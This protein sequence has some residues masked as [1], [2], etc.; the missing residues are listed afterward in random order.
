MPNHTLDDTTAA[1][2]YQWPTCTGCQRPLRENELTRHACRPCQDRATRHLDTIRDLY[3][4]L[5]TAAALTPTARAGR[6]DGPA[7][8][9]IHAPLPLRV[10]VIDLTAP[11]GIGTR[12]QA[13]EDSWR[14]A[15]GRPVH[16]RT[17]AGGRTSQT[18]DVPGHLTF[19][20]MNLERAC[21]SYDS[22]GDDLTELARLAAACQAA[23]DTS[24]RPARVQVGTCP[25][26]LDG[27]NVCGTALTAST[28]RH[29]I[30]CPGCGNR[31]DGFTAWR[32]L[33]A[34]QNTLTRAAA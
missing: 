28:G 31:W 32:D 24:P 8:S 17:F 3:P 29:T 30:T 27:S 20:A 34:A 9:K 19:I 26:R 6:S 1:D 16:V 18:T 33:R 4:H 11:G 5:N 23:L 15:F 10:D 13:I 2:D 7:P 12:L 14:I 21:E 22:I 25:A